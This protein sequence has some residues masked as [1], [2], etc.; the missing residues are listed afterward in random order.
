MSSIQVKRPS[1]TV[2]TAQKPPEFVG[3]QFINED[4]TALVKAKNIKC[5]VVKEGQDVGIDFNSRNEQA[6][7]VVLKGK[8]PSFLILL[9]R[10]LIN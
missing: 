1:L 2:S 4:K 10:C 8:Y 9:A 3:V 6:T 5:G 7:V